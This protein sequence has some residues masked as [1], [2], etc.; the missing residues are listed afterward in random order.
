MLL[1]DAD[2]VAVAVA[3]KSHREKVYHMLQE[4]TQF[5]IGRENRARGSW[6]TWS[7]WSECSRTCGT[8]VQSQSRECVPLRRDL[9]KRSPIT[10]ND[11]TQN[12]RPICIG[13]YKRYHTCNTQDCP[14]FADDL[15]TEQCAKYNEKNYKGHVYT[16]IPFLDAPNSCALNCRAVGQRFYATLEPSVIDGT[17]CDGPNLRGH[18]TGISMERTERWLCVAGQCKPVGCDGVIGSGATMDACGVCGGRGQGCRSFEGIFMEP[19]LPKGHY[20]I[21]TIP[22]GAMSLNISELRFSSNFL[23]IVLKMKGSIDQFT[24]L[25]D[26]N[27]SYILNGPWSYSPSGTYKAAGTTLTYQRGDRNRLECILATG[28]LNDTLRLEIL[29]QEMNPGILYKYML[30]IKGVFTEGG[31]EG[32]GGGGGG[33]VGGLGERIL[34]PPISEPISSNDQRGNEIPDG[35]SHRIINTPLTRTSI[36]R[37]ADFPQSQGGI[38]YEHTRHASQTEEMKRPPT[39]VMAGDQPNSKMKK[40]KRKKFIWKEFG[41]TSCSKEC[42]GGVQ[43][44]TWK[45]VRESTEAIVVHDKRCR[46]IEKPTTSLVIRC[47]EHP[48]PARWRAENWSECSVTCGVGKRTRKLECIQEL[49]SRMTMRVAPGACTKPP[50]LKTEELCSRPAC[51]IMNTPELRH[52]QPLSVSVSSSTG[53]TYSQSTQRWN[54]GAWGSCSTSCGKGF[55]ERTV[56]CITSGES[57]PLSSKP[58]SREECNNAPCLVNNENESNS[59]RRSPWLHSTWSPTCSTECGI[60]IES[61][62]VAC[63]EGS[64]LFCDPKEKPETERQCFGN[65]TNCENAKWFTGP[66]TSCS[67]SCGI[68]VQY[69]DVLCISKTTKKNDGEYTLVEMKNCN[70]TKPRSEQVCEIT[71]C[72]A[73]WYT[74]DWSKCSATCGSGLQT[75]LVRCILEGVSSSDCKEF[76]KPIEIQQ[77]NVEPCKKNIT[78]LTRPPKKVLESTE[79]VEKNPECDLA[80]KSGICH[81]KYYKYTCCRCRD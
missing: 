76:T 3:D 2:A 78:L 43:T 36:I 6:G 39:T 63:S 35:G 21:T 49:N 26:S 52:M 8:G 58:T 55:K 17:P 33:G 1:V 61:R 57:C 23:E 53:K 68:G 28:P 71:P 4:R 64:E 27:G 24:A 16:W 45:C 31:E 18:N 75:R 5:G 20:S 47:N 66:W 34:I 25:R 54:V 14:N 29:F 37:R 62:R 13:I 32:G 77:C 72:S 22:K 65:A 67:V 15:R 51:P 12:I 60:G 73:E 81:R 19:I 80:V 50:D 9:R 11:T 41:P 70:S 46:Y 69:R 48:C 56:T 40:K 30:P 10:E 79:C 44:S 59:E 42:G 7:S 38:H 74:S